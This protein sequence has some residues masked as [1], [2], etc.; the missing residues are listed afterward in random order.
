MSKLEKLN[1]IR[2]SLIILIVIL[3]IAMSISIYVLA[4]NSKSNYN[5]G[6]KTR[7]LINYNC[8]KK[9][10][11]CSDKDI[12]N[13][14]KVA[15]KVN[16]KETYDFYLIANDAETATFIMASNIKN[17]VDWHIEGINFRG[18]T[19]AY[20]ELAAATKDWIYIPNIIDFEYN[21]GGN[22]Y[23]HNTCDT[24]GAQA[25]NLAYDCRDNII[26]ARGYQKLEILEDGLYIQMNLP[27]GST[28]DEGIFYE[29]YYY[30]RLPSYEELRDISLIDLPDWLIDNLEDHTGYWTMTSSTYPTSNYDTAAY[31]MVNKD[32]KPLLLEMATLNEVMPKYTIGIRPIITID[33][34]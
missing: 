19:K 6:Y 17:E 15:L 7:S 9:G 23:Y 16:E 14:I 34:A 18:P 12:Y 28:M 25:L 1:K 24:I 31:A 26:P 32:G 3:L 30:A 27:A 11:I 20:R 2:I 8:L 29:G 22:I 33:K 21:D 10:E 13:S 5:A 4:K